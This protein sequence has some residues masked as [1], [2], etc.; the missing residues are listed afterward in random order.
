MRPSFYFWT[1]CYVN[2]RH[3]TCNT[4]NNYYSID[5]GAQEHNPRKRYFWFLF[6]SLKYP[7]H[8]ND[9]KFLT[10]SFSVEPMLTTSLKYSSTSGNPLG[11]WRASGKWKLSTR[12]P[13][14]CVQWMMVVWVSA[15]TWSCCKCI[16]GQVLHGFQHATFAQIK[17]S[18][19][20]AK[21]TDWSITQ[22]ML[23][24]SPQS[25]LSIRLYAKIPVSYLRKL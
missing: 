11:L 15:G 18:R 10:S 6:V 9:V 22:V 14:S 2:W 21:C 23:H 24:L 7:V 20:V 12:V 5:I 25:H 17:K 13:N 4:E 19:N 8:Q 16:P 1:K 3:L